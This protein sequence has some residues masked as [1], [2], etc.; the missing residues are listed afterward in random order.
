MVKDHAKEPSLQD[1]CANF[2]PLSDL[3]D[4]LNLLAIFFLAIG[5]VFTLSASFVSRQ[6]PNLLSY[7]SA[8]TA[9]KAQEEYARRIEILDLVLL[10]AM[11]F[12][13]A[14]GVMTTFLMVHGWLKH[15]DSLDCR[16][17]LRM[18]EP[19]IELKAAESQSYG[20]IR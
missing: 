1:C 3:I 18:H 11:F 10:T 8:R 14:G 20:T 15:E 17:D 12:V 7:P 5:L 19:E 4:F 16:S 13:A 6:Q 2:S 9:E